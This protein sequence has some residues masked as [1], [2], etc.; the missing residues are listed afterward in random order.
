MKLGCGGET[1]KTMVLGAD[2]C[3]FPTGS[4]LAEAEQF[5]TAHRGEVAFV[6]IDVGA[7]D[8]FRYGDQATATI[9]TYLPQILAGLRA[10]VG[11]GVPIIGMNYRCLPAGNLERDA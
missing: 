10:A 1:T 4:Q 7:N 11:P 8:T 5:L 9:I 6:T 3:G 2:Y